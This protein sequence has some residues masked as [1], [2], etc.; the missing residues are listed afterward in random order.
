MNRS[1]KKQLILSV[2][3]SL[4]EDLVKKIEYLPDEWDGHEIRKWIA[5]YYTTNYVIGSSL[6]GRRLKDYKNDIIVKNLI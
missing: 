1:D 4:R 5:D 3:D 6:I 2:C